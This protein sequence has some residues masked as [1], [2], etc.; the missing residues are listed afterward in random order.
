MTHSHAERETQ[1]IHWLQ[2]LSNF[3]PD[4]FHMISGDASFRRYF[5]CYSNGSAFIAVDAPPQTEKN[6][7]FVALAKAYHAKGV[8]VPEVLEVDLQ[9]GFLLLQD[10]GDVLFSQ[11]I[12]E[13]NEAQWYAKALAQLPHIQ[14]V[15]EVKASHE[16]Q[17]S[18]MPL[19]AF[20]DALLEAEFHLFNHWLLVVHLGLELTDVE[21]QIIKQAQ[22]FL[23]SVFLAQ[24]QVGVHR[25]YHSRN[26]M[27]LANDEI[28]VIDFQDAVT[29]PITYDA[30]SLLRDCY[31]V[32]PDE[33]VQSQLKAL[34]QQYYSQYDWAAFAHWFDC[35]GMQRHIKAS[36]IFARLCH[37]D[38]KTSYLN[39]IPRTLDYLV[40]IGRNIPQCADFAVLVDTKIKPAVEVKNR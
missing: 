33:F 20:D 14:Q 7:A 32:W 2:T 21:W 4:N 26:L 8:A 10:F 11:V 39:D 38:G 29:G 34:H 3:Q 18:M 27:I 12:S 24:P 31:V 37:R 35:V 16:Q 22:D 36:G 13:G 1:L 25:D 23:T 15:T 40:R 19:P 6:Q 30:V 17:H 28:G 9:N 5:R